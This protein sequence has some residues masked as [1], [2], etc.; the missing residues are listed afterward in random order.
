MELGSNWSYHKPLPL[1]LTSYTRFIFHP[2]FDLSLELCAIQIIRYAIASSINGYFF[3]PNPSSSVCIFHL[4]SSCLQNHLPLVSKSARKISRTKNCSIGVGGKSFT[5]I[6]FCKCSIYWWLQ[7]CMK[8]TVRLHVFSFLSIF[9]S[10][11]FPQEYQVPI[12]CINPYKIHINNPEYIDEFTMIHQG[13]RWSK[14]GLPK[15]LD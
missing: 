14:I 2:I 3:R 6:L 7:K 15:Q 8:N 1:N 12:V 4:Q 5:T 11:S 13:G 10:A 9:P